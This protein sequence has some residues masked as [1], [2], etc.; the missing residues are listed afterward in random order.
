MT[1][2]FSAVGWFAIAVAV[3]LFQ[4]QE[5]RAGGWEDHCENSA[6]GCDGICYTPYATCYPTNNFGCRCGLYIA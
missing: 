5:V 2:L 1:R 4:V 3:V 6:S